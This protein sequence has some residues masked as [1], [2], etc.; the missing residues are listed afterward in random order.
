MDP[1]FNINLFLETLDR[2]LFFSF[3]FFISIDFLSANLP[4]SFIWEKGTLA[5]VERTSSNKRM[6][7]FVHNFPGKNDTCYIEMKL[8]EFDYKYTHL[9]IFIAR[10]CSKK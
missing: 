10:D 6:K 2:L 5:K 7:E 4:K 3:Y 9:A 1:M 8:K